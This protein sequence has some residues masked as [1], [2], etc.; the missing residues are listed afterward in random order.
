MKV[1]SY[2]WTS[3]SDAAVQALH[4]NTPRPHAPDVVDLH[5]EVER[6]AFP[7]RPRRDT[8]IRCRPMRPLLIGKRA[9]AVVVV[10]TDSKK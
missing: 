5:P 10:K 4:L 7:A 8:E 9:E 2:C 3:D 1:A 6:V